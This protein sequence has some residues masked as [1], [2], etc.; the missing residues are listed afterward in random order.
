MKK[1]APQNLRARVAKWTCNQLVI[2]R[3]REEP[4]ALLRKLADSIE[5]L[6]AIDVLDITYSSSWG[7]TPPEITATLYFALLDDPKSDPAAK[8]QPKKLRRPQAPRKAR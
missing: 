2:T 4:A 5:Q 1:R 8:P 7:P 3:P 6:G